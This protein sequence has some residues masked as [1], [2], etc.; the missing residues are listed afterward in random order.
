MVASSA[1]ACSPVIPG[2]SLSGDLVYRIYTHPYEL[3]ETNR[4]WNA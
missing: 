2:L 1:C 4:I 3:Q